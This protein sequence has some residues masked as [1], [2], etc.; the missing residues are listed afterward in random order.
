MPALLQEITLSIRIG[1]IFLKTKIIY[2]RQPLATL[3]WRSY[4]DQMFYSQRYLS[5]MRNQ[6]DTNLCHGVTA[7]EAFRMTTSNLAMTNYTDCVASG[8][9]DVAT[10]T[11]RAFAL[12]MVQSLDSKQAISSDSTTIVFPFSIIVSLNDL[13]VVESYWTT[14]LKL[15]QCSM[16]FKLSILLQMIRSIRRQFIQLCYNGMG[17]I[18]HTI[19]STVKLSRANEPGHI[20]SD[21]SLLHICMLDIQS[22]D[23]Y[24]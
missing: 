23:I 22:N 4:F 5:M 21:V 20:R 16:I 24:T 7:F 19:S 12:T 14:L 1:K 2:T 13:W 10:G 6:P 18:S 8:Q 17:K 9:S 3:V 15:H 11:T